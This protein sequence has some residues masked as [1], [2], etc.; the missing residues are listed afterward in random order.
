MNGDRS[1]RRNIEL[2]RCLAPAALI[3]AGILLGSAPVAAA[4]P[5]QR[6]PNAP[7]RP[8][9][10]FLFGQPRGWI[11]VSGS[12]VVP[13]AEGDLFAFIHN[14]LTVEKRDFKAPAVAF[15]GGLISVL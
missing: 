9:P 10:D 8:R 3:L 12:L 1:G 13:R 2:P 7:D 5:D 6:V 14:Q 15:E 4:E 11:G